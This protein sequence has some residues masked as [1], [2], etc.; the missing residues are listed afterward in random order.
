MLSSVFSLSFVLRGLSLAQALGCLLFLRFLLPVPSEGQLGFLIFFLITD[1]CPLLSHKG[2]CEQLYYHGQSRTLGI[3]W[4]FEVLALSL[5][6]ALFIPSIPFSLC[7]LFLAHASLLGR[8]FQ[9]GLLAD[10]PKSL[11]K[12]SCCLLAMPWFILVG[13]YQHNP[14]ALWA[15]L[16]G[17]LCFMLA[18]LMLFTPAL[19]RWHLE[20]FEWELL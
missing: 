12:L 10:L 14:E 13:S 6:P 3:I 1:S 18:A 4:A 15:I 7:V 9:L 8:L 16:C 2:L 20:P 11:H 17:L 19:L 5:F